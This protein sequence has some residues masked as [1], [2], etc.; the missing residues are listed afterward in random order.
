MAKIWFSRPGTQPDEGDLKGEKEISWRKYNLGP[1]LTF[2]V[3]IEEKNNDP[4]PGYYLSTL[5]PR[6]YGRS[7]RISDR[8][9]LYVPG[10]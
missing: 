7:S 1:P 3:E 8:L 2:M 6:Q 5:M 10:R 4:D 9:D